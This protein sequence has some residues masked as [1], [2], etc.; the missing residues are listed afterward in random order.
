[1]KFSSIDGHGHSHGSPDIVHGPVLHFGGVEN[2]GAEAHTNVGS[3][4]TEKLEKK[5]IA[6]VAWM[7]I[8]GD[9]LH[10]FIDGLAIGASF[11]SSAVVG[12]ST[13]LA[14]ISEEIPHELGRQFLRWT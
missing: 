8:L 7:I 13:S 3:I 6:T 10:N 14:I 9:G 11:S 1:M 4:V 5:A 2:S 12:I